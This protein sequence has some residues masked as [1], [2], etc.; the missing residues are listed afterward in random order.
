MTDIKDV[1]TV[2]MRNFPH[3]WK[4]T[5]VCLSV[6]TTLLL[7]DLSNPVGLV[8]IG[9]PSSGKTTVLSFFYGLDDIVFK[10]DEF[11]PKSFV[12]HYAAKT[13]EELEKI[14]LLPKIKDKVMILPEMGVVFGKR[15]EDLTESL[16]VL[17]KVFDGEGYSKDSGSVGHREYSGEY[18]FSLLGATTPLSNHVWKTMGKLGARWFFYTVPERRESEDSLLRDMEE[19]SYKDRVMECRK[20]ITDFLLDVWSQNAGIKGVKWNPKQ[21]DSNLRRDIIRLAK[22]VGRLRG[23]VS[24]S[25]EKDKEGN[26]VFS[27]TIPIIEEPKRAINILYNIARGHAII[28]GR[29]SITDEDIEI[30]RSVALSSAPYDRVKLFNLLLENNGVLDYID[31][32]KELGCSRQHAYRIME[33]LGILRLVDVKDGDS[34][35]EY[36]TNRKHIVLKDELK[37]G[38]N[39]KT[40]VCRSEEADELLTIDSQIKLG[41]HR[42]S[43][44]TKEKIVQNSTGE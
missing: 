39:M 30:V 12:S 9:A 17:T 8:L 28:N 31:I 5:R 42:Y 11:S 20:V 29:A 2:V 36:S 26:L 4:E 22:V 35:D 21:D 24:I 33:T 6:A 32:E 43:G 15:A 10:T 18:L 1:E 14:D 38:C 13:E 40:P 27:Y 25:G 23:V 44:V 19:D 37:I 34:N 3:L 7:E 16:A 41:T